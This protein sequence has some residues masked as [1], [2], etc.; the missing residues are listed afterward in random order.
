MF[1]KWI[2]IVLATTAGSFINICCGMHSSW[3]SPSLIKLQAEDSPIPITNDQSTW[4][5]NILFL[6]TT[7]GAIVWYFLALRLTKRAVALATSAPFV[8]SWLII[9]FARSY[10]LLLLARL[11]AGISM[12]CVFCSAPLFLAEVSGSARRGLVVSFI[13]LSG[14]FGSFLINLVGSFV[15]IRTTALVSLIFP[16]LSSCLFALIPDSPYDLIQQRRFDDAETSLKNFRGIEDVESDFNRI[17]E[18][19]EERGAGSCLDLIVVASYRKALMMLL[20]VRTLCQ[21][22]GISTVEVYS[23]SIFLDIGGEDFAITLS[24]IYFLIPM[25]FTIVSLCLIDSVGR[26]PLMLLA[27]VVIFVALVTLTVLYYLNDSNRIE[28][29]VFVYLSSGA[30]LVYVAVFSLGLDFA[31]GV[32]LGEIFSPGLKSFA[33]TI[34][35]L[36]HGFLKVTIIKLFQ[37]TEEKFGMK[38]PFLCFAICTFF[39]IF[40]IVYYVPETKKK[41]LEEIQMLLGRKDRNESN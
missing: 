39:S 21:L 13:T 3:T 35:E 31:P 9:A 7:C 25:V 15:S 41:N 36:Y 24:S 22:T 4:I 26:K 14:S 18:A 33:S 32:I 40:F 27:S 5:A 2:Y 11:L 8:V 19:V 16:V 37:I 10:P 1:P 6:G 29:P 23:Q 28:E 38:V 30:L 34:N 17:R 20:G 12:G